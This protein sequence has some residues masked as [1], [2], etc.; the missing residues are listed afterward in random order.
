MNPGTDELPMPSDVRRAAGLA[1]LPGG[2][3]VP[4]PDPAAPL[5]EPPSVKLVIRLFLIPFLI[6]AA[7]VGIMMII[8]GG[9]A[10]GPPTVGEAIERMKA[11][12]GGGGRTAGHLV[13]PGS[14]QL[15]MDAMVLADQLR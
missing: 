4:A 6:V 10:S 11:A 15:Y 7:A 1:P 14:K 8:R 9:V 2:L 3:G 12:E 5:V 13:G